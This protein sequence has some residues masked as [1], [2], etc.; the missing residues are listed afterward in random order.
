[1]V[2]MMKYLNCFVIFLIFG[3]RPSSSEVAASIVGFDNKTDDDYIIYERPGSV[4]GEGGPVFAAGSVGWN[5]V[6]IVRAHE[7]GEYELLLRDPGAIGVQIKL[8]PQCDKVTPI[9]LKGGIKES[10]DCIQSWFYGPF[11]LNVAVTEDALN[12]PFKKYD[13]I[14]RVRYCAYRTA[15]SIIEIYPDGI[16]LVE[17]HNMKVLDKNK[18]DMSDIRKEVKREAN[19]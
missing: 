2:V 4:S 3:V 13:A 1:M 6:L 7:K 15:S 12:N 19:K 14:K 5:P 17:M 11:G 10:G 9:Y 16:K 8:E 18:V